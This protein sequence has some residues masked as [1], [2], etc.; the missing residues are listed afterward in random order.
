MKKEKLKVNKANNHA[1]TL[2]A[3]II[4]IIILLILAGVTINILL[5]DN[6][7]FNTAKD[8]AD[9]YRRS[10]I[11]EKLLVAIADLQAQ[12]LGRATLEDITQ[13]WIDSKMQGY[14]CTVKD[15]ITTNTKIIKVEKD[16]K[17][18]TFIIDEVLN[19]IESKGKVN[20]FYDVINSDENN[21][22]ISMTIFGNIGINKIE[23]PGKDPIICNGEKEINDIEYTAPKGVEHIIKVTLTNGEVEE[24]KIVLNDYYD[25][26]MNLEE[27][28]SIDN[29]SKRVGAKTTYEATLTVGNLEYFLS[30]LKVTVD[31]IL[32]NDESKVNVRTRKN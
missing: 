8:A 15:D 17:I 6:G 32:I 10:E 3:L 27:G 16:G 18:E 12:K 31:G 26:I 23:F 11:S 24:L 21:M 14:E 2:I 1:I 4:T 5:G 20:Y 30:Q 29:K 25:V 7:L 19:I 9:R 22:T 13:E 28:I